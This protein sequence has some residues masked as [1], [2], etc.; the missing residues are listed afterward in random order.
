MVSPSWFLKV[1]TISEAADTRNFRLNFALMFTLETLVSQLNTNF[2]FIQHST[3][4]YGQIY[5]RLEQPGNSAK[6]LSNQDIK[7]FKRLIYILEKQ[8]Q[9]KNVVLARHPPQHISTKF[10]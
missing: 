8:Q 1:L 3:N 4:F 6:I 5:Q 7:I 9:Q 2:S 10:N